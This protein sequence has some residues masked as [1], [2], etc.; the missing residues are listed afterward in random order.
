MKGKP[1]KKRGEKMKKEAMTRKCKNM[2]IKWGLGGRPKGTI[3]VKAK[4]GKKKSIK[5]T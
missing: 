5:E 4:G 3:I 2:I 1:G